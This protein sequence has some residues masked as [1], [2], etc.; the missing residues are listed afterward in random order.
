MANGV[1]VPHKPLLFT[2][3]DAV[4]QA[5][6]DD[7]KGEDPATTAAAIGYVCHVV[8][9][10]SCYLSVPLPYPA[11]PQLSTSSIRDDISMMMMVQGQ[12][13]FPLYPKNSVQYRFDYALFLL[14]KNIEFL[15]SR[16]GLKVLDLRQTLPNLKY[17][18]CVL[19]SG[20]G[21]GRGGGG[22]NGPPA[23]PPRRLP[24]HVKGLLRD[25]L[26]ATQGSP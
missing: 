8:H 15:T 21:G 25:R 5:L 19:M 26:V 14:N 1:Q 4:L 12:R 24:G 23:A 16:H 7:S 13:T 9:L 3:R 6:S 2:I 10:L 17:L 11:E 18:V 20:D 22:R